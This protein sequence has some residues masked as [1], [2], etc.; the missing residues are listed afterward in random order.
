MILK[1]ITKSSHNRGVIFLKKNSRNSLSFFIEGD[2]IGTN[3]LY[4]YH[5]QKINASTFNIK[6]IKCDRYLVLRN[7]GIPVL[8]DTT[9]SGQKCYVYDPNVTEEQLLNIENYSNPYHRH[10][11]R[12]TPICRA[13]HT[14]NCEKRKFRH[15][16]RIFRTNMVRQCL[17]FKEDTPMEVFKVVTRLPNIIPNGIDPNLH[18]NWST[19][20]DIYKP[21]ELKAVR[22]A[23]FCEEDS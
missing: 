7:Q 15:I 13:K 2:V 21:R 1:F 11:L 14:K 19:V 10:T 23:W 16:Q 18:Y 3:S 5:I 6:C 8:P 12:C 17:K 20:L 9:V 22:Y 4:E